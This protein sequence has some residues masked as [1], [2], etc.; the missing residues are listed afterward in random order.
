MRKNKTKW[1]NKTKELIKELHKEISLTSKNWHELK[2]LPERR[3]AE[4]L[5]GALA[6]LINDGKITD[7]EELICQ[8]QKWIKKEVKDPG[9]PRN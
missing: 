8:S 2:A 5:I 4:L 6:Q 9:C 3:A 7:V 1:T